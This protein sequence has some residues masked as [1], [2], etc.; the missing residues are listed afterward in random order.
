LD[1]HRFSQSRFDEGQ[2]GERRWPLVRDPGPHH[3]VL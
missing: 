1:L 3:V 2:P